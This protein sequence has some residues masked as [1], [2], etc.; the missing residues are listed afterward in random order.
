MVLS[1]QSTE[2]A[3]EIAA[4]DAIRLSRS[5]RLKSSH[6]AEYDTGPRARVVPLI[7]PN[8]KQCHQDRAASFLHNQ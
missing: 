6:Q 1:Q 2:I 7:F 8:V 4:P 3:E 5:P